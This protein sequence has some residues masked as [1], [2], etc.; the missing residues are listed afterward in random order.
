MFNWFF[1]LVELVVLAF[2]IVAIVALV[3]AINLRKLVVQLDLRLRT[4]EHDL[5]TRPAPTTPAA[6]EPSVAAE[7]WSKGHRVQMR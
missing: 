5:A 7:P 1:L 2:P 6:P 3:I 4:L